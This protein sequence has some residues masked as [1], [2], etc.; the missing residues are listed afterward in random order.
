VGWSG[1]LEKWMAQ[2]LG[3]LNVPLEDLGLIPRTHGSSQL[4]VVTRGDWLFTL[5]SWW[6]PCFSVS[7][8]QITGPGWA[9]RRCTLFHLETGDQSHSLWKLG[10]HP[11]SWPMVIKIVLIILP[12]L[13]WTPRLTWF[14]CPRP[15][16]PPWLFIWERGFLCSFG[17]L[18]THDVAQ[19][20]LE[21]TEVH[22]PL[23]PECWG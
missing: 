8:A 1:G 2:Q 19:A 12:R 10:K 18:R 9:V 6:S 23:P 3:T 22:L 13:A 14:S 17:C 11:V 21:L 16:P 7:S 15:P 20:G 5:N 4:S